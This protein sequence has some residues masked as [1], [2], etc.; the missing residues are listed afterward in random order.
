ML[1]HKLKNYPI[2]KA[3]KASHKFIQLKHLITVH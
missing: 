2:N 3:Y 1:I